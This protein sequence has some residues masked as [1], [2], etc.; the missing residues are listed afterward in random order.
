MKKVFTL[1]GV[2]PVLVGAQALHK[3]V[4]TLVILLEVSLHKIVW[5]MESHGKNCR[6]KAGNLTVWE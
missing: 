4:R 5:K 6:T 3:K 1:L 2:D